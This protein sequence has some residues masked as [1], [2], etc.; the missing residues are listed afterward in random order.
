MVDAE[1]PNYDEIEVSMVS[2]FT[3]NKNMF[4]LHVGSEVLEMEEGYEITRFNPPR[5]SHLA[6]HLISYFIELSSARWSS[7]KSRNNERM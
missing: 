2:K 5:L 7:I 6:M 3:E 1:N 4:R